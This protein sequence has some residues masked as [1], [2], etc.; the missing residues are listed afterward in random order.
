MISFYTY[1]K[2]LVPS[3]LK[4]T[5]K[6]CLG[7][8]PP[9]SP[10][11]KI[12]PELLDVYDKTEPFIYNFAQESVA[13]PTID[14][15]SIT[16]SS[17]TK[18]EFFETSF[19]QYWYPQLNYVDTEY[20]PN[21]VFYHRKIWEHIYIIQAFYERN[22]LANN[23]RGLGFAV[24]IEPLPALF[25]K[26]GCQIVATDLNRDN[27]NKLGWIQSEQHS[28]NDLSALNR[29]NICPPDQFNKHVS[30]RNVDMNAIPDDLTDFD[31]CWSSCAFEHLGSI[32]QGLAFVINSMKTLKPG[33]IAIHT[34]EYNLSSDTKTIDNNP[35][36]VIFRKQDI[37]K[38]V[39]EL[40]TCGYSVL[41]LDLS[42]GNGIIDAFV[43]LPPYFR[44]KMHLKL[45]LNGYV[46]TSIGLIIRKSE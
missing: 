46:V 17:L 40:T 6:Q 23:K 36:F 45:W 44:K 30:F 7:L 14:D 10:L 35:N 18:Q 38:L 8:V 42:T 41:P 5:I 31:F 24:G 4:H 29:N 12:P 2:K 25:A 26:L 3:S 16:T 1:I 32:E 33:G 15:L 19:F 39:Q 27:A 13:A 37:L 9:Q 22:Y 34:T 11:Q 28:N 43:D 21:D 20:K